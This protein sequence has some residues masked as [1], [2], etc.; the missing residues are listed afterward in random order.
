MYEKDWGGIMPHF[1]TMKKHNVYLSYHF[2]SIHCSVSENNGLRKWRILLY[3]S[4]WFT[5]F[6]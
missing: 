3:V 2:K 1:V 5:K 6:I 4:P